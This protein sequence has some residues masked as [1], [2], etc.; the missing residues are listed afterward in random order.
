MPTIYQDTSIKDKLY[1]TVKEAVDIVK[2]FNSEDDKARDSRP[3]KS[4]LMRIAVVS[5]RV[6]G[7]I[8]TRNTALYGYE[9]NLVSED[10][11]M[12]NKLPETKQRLEDIINYFLVNHA[13]TALFDSFAV[14]LKWEL[15]NNSQ[16]AVIDYEYLPVELDILSDGTL[17]IVDGMNGKTPINKTDNSIFYDCLAPRER[18]GR[19]RSIVFHELLRNETMLEWSNLNKRMKGIVLG[20]IKSQELSKA[21]ALL[22]MNETQVQSMLSNLDTALAGAG[23]QNYLKTIDAVDVQMK[24]LVEAAAGNSFNTFKQVLDADIAIA[25]LGQANTSELPNNGGSRAAVQ[26]LNLIRTD[27]LYADMIA[28]RNRINRFLQ[29]DYKV[30]NGDNPTIVCPYKFKFIDYETVDYEQN[31]RIYEVMQRIGVPVVKSEF[32]SNLNMTVP[33]DA[34]DTLEL[35]QQATSFNAGF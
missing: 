2:K 13:T 35:K 26:I 32:Y 22:N 20:L 3:L 18:G 34:N 16:T 30:N 11:I 31:A 5:P 25:L 28:C 24:S 17:A 19:L 12:Q 23:E 8:L 4:V 14:R 7:H 27:I 33:T 21:A 15:L 10:K 1:P 9:W 6:S 29:L